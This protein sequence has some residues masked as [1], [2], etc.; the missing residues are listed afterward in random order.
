MEFKQKIDWINYVFEENNID[1]VHFMSWNKIIKTK[2]YV[3]MNGLVLEGP[4]N[5]GKSL[6]I[7]NLIEPTKPEEIPR[8]RDN[9]RFHLDQLPGASG[10]LFEEPI[11]TP[12]NIGTWKLLLQGKIVKTNI[13]HKDKEVIKRLPIY[14][15]TATPVTY[16]IDN[17]ET[18]QVQQRIKIFKF[19]KTITHREDNYTKSNDLTRR[20]INRAP[21]LIK[22]IHFAFVYIQN[23]NRIINKIYQEDIEHVLN[24]NNRNNK[25]NMATRKEWQTLIQHGSGQQLINFFELF[26]EYLLIIR[27]LIN[28]FGNNSGI[29]AKSF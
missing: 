20:S 4:T 12:T 17:R 11:I 26:L 21:G 2:R 29:Y 23:W 6:I 28:I 25:N 24:N 13:K 15:T 9:S 8:E 14:I 5:A 1:I 10:A 3:K 27:R 18:L 19:I 7:D 22:P 16:N